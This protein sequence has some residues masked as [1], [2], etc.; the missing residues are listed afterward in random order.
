MTYTDIY[1]I[2]DKMKENSHV[3]FHQGGSGHICVNDYYEMKMSPLMEKLKRDIE[4]MV[5]FTDRNADV[6]VHISK[7]NVMNT[8]NNVPNAQT[9]LVIIRFEGYKYL[10][11]RSKE[12]YILMNYAKEGVDIC[13]RDKENEWDILPKGGLCESTIFR[14]NQQYA[15]YVVNTYT[16]FTSFCESHLNIP[17]SQLRRSCNKDFRNALVEMFSGITFPEGESDC[18]YSGVLNGRTVYV[19]LVKIY[20]VIIVADWIEDD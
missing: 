18:V 15:K 10:L 14:L 20:N 8:V 17:R 9:Y 5:S 6:F 13:K 11:V 16:A 4:H 19:R 12:L 7:D 1:P 2:Y 3:I